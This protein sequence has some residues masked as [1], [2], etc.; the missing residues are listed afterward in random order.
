MIV[1]GENDCIRTKDLDVNV[2]D[3]RHIQEVLCLWEFNL[4]AIT[5]VRY[6]SGNAET[7]VSVRAHQGNINFTVKI[8]IEIVMA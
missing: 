3:E 7:F 2:K 4:C 5:L 6:P 1:E 8:L